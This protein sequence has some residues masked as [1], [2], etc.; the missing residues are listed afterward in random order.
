[1]RKLSTLY[2]IELKLVIREISGVLFGVVIP[3]GLIF[4]LGA[5]YGD[6]TIS[7]TSNITMFQQAVPGVITIGL[8]AS[9]L[10]G[11][12]LAI[13]NYRDKRILR[14]YQVTPTSPLILLFVQV[15]VQ[16]TIA[17]ISA[18]LV[19]AVAFIFFGYSMIG[20]PLAF[21]G[22]YILLLLSIFSIGMLIASVSNNVNTV[23]MAE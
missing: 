18:A 15:F 17:I 4:L 21:I 1:M 12:P 13:A 20:S 2:F 9:G 10:M 11:L 19:L 22:I 7:D 16:A 6:K 8:C 14:R 3:V 5:L 23:Y